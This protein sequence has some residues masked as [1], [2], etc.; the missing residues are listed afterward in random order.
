MNVIDDDNNN[1]DDDFTLIMNGISDP[2]SRIYACRL[3]VNWELH[4]Q[5]ARRKPASVKGN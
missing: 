1:T 2:F 4:A 3:V 5:A